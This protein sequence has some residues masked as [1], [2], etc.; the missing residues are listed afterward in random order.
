MTRTAL[1]SVN[2]GA[3]RQIAPP[4]GGQRAH[5]RAGRRRHKNRAI[6][7]MGMLGQSQGAGAAAAQLI[8]SSAVPPSAAIHRS[9]P[10]RR[11]IAAPPAREQQRAR[12]RRPWSRGERPRCCPFAV[13]VVAW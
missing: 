10:I 13:A 3:M 5:A 11:S 4:P 1:P 8:A 7:A 9:P 12:R 6:Q 2:A